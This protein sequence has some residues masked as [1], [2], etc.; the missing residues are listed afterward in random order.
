MATEFKIAIFILGIVLAVF[1]KAEDRRLYFLSAYYVFL[2]PLDAYFYFK[3]LLLEYQAEKKPWLMEGF[4]FIP[5]LRAYE[6]YDIAK[7]PMEMNE[8]YS[9]FYVDLSDK[10]VFDYLVFNHYFHVFIVFS[11]CVL[12][13]Y[14]LTGYLRLILQRYY[15]G[16]V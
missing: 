15:Y 10:G 16:R 13:S 8:Y 6:D 12:W 11:C 14:H 5:Y 2:V 1:F 9:Q 7:K 3:N 4:N